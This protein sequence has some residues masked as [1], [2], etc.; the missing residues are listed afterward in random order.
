MSRRGM[1]CDGGVWQAIIASIAGTPYVDL[2]NL[3]SLLVRVESI[4]VQDLRREQADPDIAAQAHAYYLRPSN[5]QYPRVFVQYR[6]GF[7]PVL[8]RLVIY[9]IH[10]SAAQGFQAD[11]AVGVSTL[12]GLRCDRGVWREAQDSIPLMTAAELRGLLT[13]FSNFET[14]SVEALTGLQTD[15]TVADGYIMSSAAV[16]AYPRIH[17]ERRRRAGLRGVVADNAGRRQS[18]IIIWQMRVSAAHAAQD[19]VNIQFE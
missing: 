16:G 7:L 3:A 2:R 19:T 6:P 1:R 14:M 5:R 4:T 8:S 18:R 17:I 15:D 11:H 12:R 9:K 10:L 13:L